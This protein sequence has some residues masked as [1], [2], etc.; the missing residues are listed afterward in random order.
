MSGI[1]YPDAVPRVKV[2]IPVVVAVVMTRERPLVEEVAKVCEEAVLPL[3]DEI[4]PR[5]PPASVPQK[6]VPLAHI[7]LS[8][9]ALHA[10]SDAPKSEASVSPPVD[11]A[12]VKLRVVA[13]RADEE[14][15]PSIVFP[16]T[17]RVPV[18]SSLPDTER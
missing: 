15:L 9:E 11:E 13:E 7:N 16:V 6:K 17:V 14:A 3:S 2:W 4:V 12:F 5:A 1:E 18:I 10:V 8:V